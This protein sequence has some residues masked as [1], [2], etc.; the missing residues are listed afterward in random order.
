MFYADLSLSNDGTASHHFTI[1][2]VLYHRLPLVYHKCTWSGVSQ[3]REFSLFI[4]SFYSSEKVLLHRKKSSPRA[5]RDANFNVD[6][7]DMIIHGL[8]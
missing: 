2:F 5:G 7:L 4:V 8:L 6:V 1:H 3:H